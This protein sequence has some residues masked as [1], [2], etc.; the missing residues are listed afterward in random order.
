MPL[1]VQQLDRGWILSL[2]PHRRSPLLPVRNEFIQRLG[3]KHV[4]AKY[5][6]AHFVALFNYTHG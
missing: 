3:L 1:S 2:P 4:A 6:G 5:V